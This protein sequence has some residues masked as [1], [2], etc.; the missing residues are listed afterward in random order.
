MLS[1]ETVLHECDDRLATR[2]LEDKL[3]EDVPLEKITLR[4]FGVQST[5]TVLKDLAANN[6]TGV[7]LHDI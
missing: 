2:L 6:E 5:M 1:A 7:S 3:E 4:T